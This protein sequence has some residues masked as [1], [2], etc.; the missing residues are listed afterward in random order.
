MLAALA[1]MMTAS[2]IDSAILLAPTVVAFQDDAPADAPPA[3]APADTPSA[4]PDDD[5]APWTPAP[6]LVVLS[7]ASAARGSLAYLQ[8]K[9]VTKEVTENVTRT[10]NNRTVVT[11]VKKTV[12]ETVVVPVAIAARSWKLLNAQ[13][14]EV[15]AREAVNLLKPGTAV[16]LTSSPKVSPVYLKA[17]AR[18]ALVVVQLP[19]QPTPPRATPL[20][21]A[22]PTPAAPR[23]RIR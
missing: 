21:T 9:I 1:L 3:E 23:A 2:V 11:P 17:M 18:D 10:I 5:I 8:T 16:F 12:Y 22:P 20:P 6:T 15:P 4:P 14:R 7:D 19:Q 13:G